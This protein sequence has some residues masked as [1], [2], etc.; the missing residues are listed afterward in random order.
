MAVMWNASKMLEVKVK[1]ALDFLRIRSII[2]IHEDMD[3]IV[4]RWSVEGNTFVAVW[5]YEFRPTI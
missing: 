5:V 4:S 2:R 3:I 1:K